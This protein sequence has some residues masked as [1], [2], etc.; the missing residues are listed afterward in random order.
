MCT[1]INLS[2]R[3][4]NMYTFFSS[5]PISAERKDF[6]FH[7]WTHVLTPP[8]CAQPLLRSFMEVLCKFER[9][10]EKYMVQ[11][12]A[13]AKCYP[14]DKWVVSK[15][16]WKFVGGIAFCASCSAVILQRVSIDRIGRIEKKMIDID[17]VDW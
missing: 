14:T 1:S 9:N 4:L 10:I 3:L 11:C 16:C 5:C 7:Y 15:L 17:C 6:H 13:G 12:R 2:A 8:P